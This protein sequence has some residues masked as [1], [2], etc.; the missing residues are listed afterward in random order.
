[1]PQGGDPG[2]LTI[3]VKFKKN[4]EV[5]I[6]PTQCVRDLKESFCYMQKLKMSSIRLFVDGQR[7]EESETVA[8]LGLQNGDIIEAFMEIT[9]GGG[10]KKR[11]LS[12]DE[13]KKRLNK[14]E[15][16]S[17]DAF[18]SSSDSDENQSPPHTHQVQVKANEDGEV[19]KPVE[20]YVSKA[21]LETP[22]TEP[23]KQMYTNNESQPEDF[24]WVDN[25]RKMYNEGKLSKQNNFHKKIIYYLELPKL[26]PMDFK[27][28]KSIMEMKEKHDEWQNE[29]NELDLELDKVQ[30]K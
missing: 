25:L 20:D 17:D 29:K 3:F 7:L 28:L 5:K 4:I 24:D 19:S 12:I 10:P 14:D 21:E 23:S 30:I 2:Y 6:K 22:H 1:M 15:D 8:N 13:V 9:G 27:I 16:K 18:S 26:E 11:G